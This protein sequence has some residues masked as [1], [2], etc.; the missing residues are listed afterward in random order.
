MAAKETNLN[1][2]V[3]VETVGTTLNITRSP[4]AGTP[5]TVAYS[6]QLGYADH[7]YLVDKGAKV[8]LL[9]Q[10]ENAKWV[11]Y[12]PEQVMS[13]FR[14]PMKRADGTDTVL[15]EFLA[16]LWDAAIQ[17]DLAAAKTI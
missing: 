12:T 5:P 13:L 2:S 10:G 17:A 1:G 3:V 11:G 6:V 14:T 15:G 4:I 16:E 8:K 9:T 7:S